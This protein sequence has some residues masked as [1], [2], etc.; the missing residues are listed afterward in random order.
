MLSVAGNE[1]VMNDDDIIVSK[2]NIKGHLVYANDIFLEIAD[3][4]AA[5]VLGKPHSI[6]RND[7]M[8]RCIFKLLWETIAAGEEIFAY[9]VNRTRNGDHYWVLAHVTPSYDASGQLSGYHSNRRR[10]GEAALTSI[11]ALYASLLAEETRHANRKEGLAASSQM[12]ATIL[13]TKGVSYDEF[14]LSL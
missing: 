11:K 2:T 1:R 4:E 9:V 10:P 3:F 14:V 7:A 6:V 12:L 8:P 5:E 13:E